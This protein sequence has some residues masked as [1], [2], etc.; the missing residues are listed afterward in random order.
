MNH[1][2]VAHIDSHMADA[3][4]VIGS[5]E[6]N[7]VAGSGVGRGNRGADIAKPLCAQPPH[8]PAGMIDDPA[9]KTG[10]VKGSGRTGAA[11]HIGIA[12]IFLRFFQHGGK[13][14][15]LQSLRRHIIVQIV[16]PAGSVGVLALGEQ[17]RPVAQGSHVNC[18]HTKLILAHRS[19]LSNVT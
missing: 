4:C 14:F 15:I 2:S 9:Y 7:E 12:Q 17:V 3:R 16:L 13:D 11:P 6:E 1:H 18:V 5:L 10:A 8:V 19:K